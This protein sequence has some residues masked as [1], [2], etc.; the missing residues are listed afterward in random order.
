MDSRTFY[1]RMSKGKFPIR[2]DRALLH[3]AEGVEAHTSSRP[4]CRTH[5]AECL[6]SNQFSQE[7]STSY[8]ET[9]GQPISAATAVYT[10]AQ[11]GS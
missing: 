3:K 7:N 9:K 10:E 11:P 1:R 8:L 5:K 4:C 2:T 6:I